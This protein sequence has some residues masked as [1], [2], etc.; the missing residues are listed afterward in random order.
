[1]DGSSGPLYQSSRFP[2]LFTVMVPEPKSPDMQKDRCHVSIL[3]D[4]TSVFMNR[5]SANW[6]LL[7]DMEIGVVTPVIDVRVCHDLSVGFSIPF[8]SFSPGFLDGPLA[9]YHKFGHFPDYGRKYKPKNEFE[10]V[11]TKDGKPWFT[12]T[13]YGFHP[14]DC[15]FSMKYSLIENPSFASALLYAV[16]L[17]T[18]DAKTGFGSGGVDHGVSLLSRF[19]KGPFALY[20]NPGVILPHDPETLGAD[21]HYRTMYTLFGGI[22][23]VYSPHWSYLIQLNT[24]TSPLSGTGITILDDPSVDIAF[25]FIRR[26]DHGSQFTFSFCED[27][28]GAVPDFTFH[29]GFETHFDL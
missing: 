22:E 7:T 5:Q 3:T 27:L 16:T 6:N 15:R 13:V 4:Y 28:S 18:G 24:F 1:M 9:D 17:P 29:A 14:G 2:T 11:V 19:S 25:G 20:L 8:I 21:I 12:P 10:W 23:Y 26:F